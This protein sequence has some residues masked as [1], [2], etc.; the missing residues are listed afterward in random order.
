MLNV[1]E[2]KNFFRILAKR[3]FSIEFKIKNERLPINRLS[4]LN[5]LLEKVLVVTIRS[6]TKGYRCTALKILIRNRK[7]TNTTFEFSAFYVQ[8]HIAQA[9]M[10]TATDLVNLLAHSKGHVLKNINLKC[11]KVL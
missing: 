5:P 7:K 9:F 3:M 6:C 8:V 11:L 1:E 4:G 10:P 2:K